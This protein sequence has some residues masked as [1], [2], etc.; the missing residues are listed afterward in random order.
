MLSTAFMVVLHQIAATTIRASSQRRHFLLATPKLTRRCHLKWLRFA[1]SLDNRARLLKVK[2]TND[3][4]SSESMDT[5]AEMG[6]SGRL[7]NQ[8]PAASSFDIRRAARIWR[9]WQRNLPIGSGF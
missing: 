9:F 4:L 7:A 8:A 3:L 5:T 6:L 1:H 2:K